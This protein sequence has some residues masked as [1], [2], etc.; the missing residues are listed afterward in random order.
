MFEHLEPVPGDPI[1]D[2]LQ[3]FMAD[4][5]PAKVNLSVG[6]YYDEQ[7]Q[8]P[9]LASVQEAQHRL[10]QA[11]PSRSY[12]PME[13]DSVYRQCVGELLFAG[14]VDT[15]H[16]AVTTVQTVGGSGALKIG[17]DFLHGAYPQA[18]VW[19][20]DPTWDNHYGIFEGAGFS[21]ERYPYYSAATQGFDY[22][23]ALATFQ[24][25]PAGSI[26]VLHPCCHN[27]TGVQPSQEQWHALLDALQAVDAVVFMDMA[28]QGLGLGLDEDAWLVRECA[29]RG[30][31]FLLASSFSKTFSLYAERVG[32]LSIVARKE[33]SAVL[34]GQLKRAVRRNYS[35]PPLFGSTLVKSVLGDP[36]LVTLWRTEL[37]GMRARIIDLRTRLSEGLSAR[38]PGRDF[39]SLLRQQGMFGYT[40]L[41]ADQVDTLRAQYGI[42]ALRSG[43]ICIAGLTRENVGRVCDAWTAVVKD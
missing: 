13:G 34:M 8:V 25:L 38:M 16:F 26:V 3:A 28:Y 31:E 7:G 42:Y 18:R 11:I 39:S 21:V 37:A 35:S 5:R 41:T 30:M 10:L 12:L 20:S 24:G 22:P 9:L 40:G 19:V 1:L 17:A 29:R 43:R 32:A 23:A 2:L 15:G 36:A 33:Q 4:P 14:S 6:I 27:P